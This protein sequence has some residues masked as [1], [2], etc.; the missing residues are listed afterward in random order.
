MTALESERRLVLG[1]QAVRE[2]LR[3][4]SGEVDEVLV[5]SGTSPRL[6]ALARFA[7]DQGAVVR[8][9]S[10]SELDALS[11]GST[12]QGAAAYAPPLQLI[13][14]EDLL[15]RPDLLAI[16]LDGV[17]DP[18]NFGAVIRS[19]VGLAR[20][21]VLWPESGS[22]PLTPATFRASAGAIE[23]AE[24]CRVRSLH[25]TLSAAALRGI[26]VVGLEPQATQSLHEV[27]FAQPSIVVIGSEEKGMARAV[28]RSCTQL[29]RLETSGAIQ[30]LNAS[31]AA[32]IALYAAF[33]CRLKT[34]I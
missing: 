27:D 15:D 18:Q 26:Q 16:A 17:V 19:A 28:R 24:L 22:A 6:D 13:P 7:G 1:L 10:R 11:R 14:P 4:R 5:Q 20:A 9:V 29:V 25:G 31:V 32:A 30:S 3:V 34:S 21:P 2:L 33:I 8:R 12:H 23:H